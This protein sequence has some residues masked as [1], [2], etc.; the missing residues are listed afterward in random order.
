MKI[1]LEI[2]DARFE[3]KLISAI[4]KEVVAGLSEKNDSQIKSEIRKIARENISEIV[5]ASMDAEVMIPQSESPYYNFTN[6]VRNDEYLTT[7]VIIE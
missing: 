4:A 7:A 2:D 1:M 5:S 6:I 3:E